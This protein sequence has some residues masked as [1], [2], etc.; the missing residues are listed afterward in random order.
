MKQIFTLRN[1]LSL[2]ILS[3]AILISFSIIA[4]AQ[5]NQI[6]FPVPELG[7]CADANACKTYCNKPE[8]ITACTAFGEAHGLISKEEA[9]RAREFADVLRGEGPGAC[10]TKEQC[11][12]YCDDITHLDEC[13]AFAEKH[14][15]MKQEELREAK[16]VAKVLKQGVSLPGNCKNKISCDRYCS[17]P[18]HSDE[19]LAFAEKAGFMTK[20]E[21]EMVKKTGGKGPGNCRSKEA[22]DAFCNQPENQQACFEFAQKNGLIPEEKLK[23]IKEGMGRLR[24]GV[25]QA[26]PEVVECLKSNL[27]QNIIEDIEAGTLVPGSQIGERVKVCFEQFMPKIKEKIESGLKNA[28]PAVVQCLENGLGGAQVLEKIKAGEAP[29]PEMGDVMKKCFELMRQEGLEKMR[30][31]LK[32]V[33]PEIRGCIQS[34]IGN[35]AEQVERGT[36][37]GQ[38]DVQGLIQDCLKDFKPSGVPEGVMPKNIPEGIKPEGIP[39]I[40]NFKP[41]I[42]PPNI[43]VPSNLMPGSDVCASFKLTPS[44]DFVPESSRALC[45]QCKGQ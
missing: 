41:Q 11:E 3:A 32:Q 16:Q 28:S 6:T 12:V 9:G 36:I 39:S 20:E 17:E 26:P 5:T 19:C 21:A 35:V 24:S 13:L 33:P 40:E 10:K 15:F 14:N 23:E 2:V 7:N 37:K 31:G 34:K 45:K 43:N 29:T 27:G 30:E 44:C 18:A 42:A 8:N 38:D 25:E 22:C 4:N 1:S